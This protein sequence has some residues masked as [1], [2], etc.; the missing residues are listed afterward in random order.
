VLEDDRE[1]ATLELRA[2][3]AGAVTARAIELTGASK[4]INPDHHLF[5]LQDDR[6][7]NMILYV[8]RGAA[9]WRRSRTRCRRAARW[10]WCGSTR[11]TTRCC[12]RTSR[13]RRRVSG[14]ARTST[15]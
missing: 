6:E 9:S 2:T 4:I 8:N 14:S 13:S 10:T 3:K 12:A 1:E 7:V 15:G 11:S 5:T